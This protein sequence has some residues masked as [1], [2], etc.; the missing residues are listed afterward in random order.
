VA[1]SVPTGRGVAVSAR[2]DVTVGASSPLSG[3]AVGGGKG[4]PC[5]GGGMLLTGACDKLQANVLPTAIKIKSIH[6]LRRRCINL[7]MPR[8]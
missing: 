3:V 6:G 8:L 2:I 7:I 5:G 1:A 4:V